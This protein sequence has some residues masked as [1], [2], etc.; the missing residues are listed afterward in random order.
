[1]GV[2]GGPSIRHNLR[3][4]RNRITHRMADGVRVPGTWR[5]VFIHNFTYHLTDLFIYA[6]G[7]IDCWELV[8]LEQF[9]K[10]LRSGWI[11]TT[12]PEGGRASGFHL[13]SW[14]FG[15]PSSH[16]EP[17]TLL[18]EIRDTIDELNDRPNSTAR[19][20][21]A[22]ATFLAHRT[23]ENRAAA[24]AAYLAIPET[25]RVYAL[26]DMD[27]K[28]RPLQVLIAGPDG[29]TQSNP[30]QRVTKAEYLRAIEYFEKQPP[31]TTE[32]TAP[33]PADGPVTAHAPAIKL[34]RGHPQ[35]PAA[36]PDVRV[37]RNEHPAPIIFGGVTYPSVAHAYWALAVAD[38]EV[39]DTIIKGDTGRLP[40]ALAAEA[41]RREGWENART[42]V[43]TGLL[44]A[45]FDQHP[46][47]AEILLTTDDGT[48]LYD[49]Q[50]AFW[51]DNGGGGRNWTGRL[52]ELVRSELQARRAGIEGL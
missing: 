2:P 25:H 42:A 29:T 6:D 31:R 4:L 33:D 35:K 36:G 27:A 30:E 44:R 40:H 9:E 5:H 46:D 15:E 32:R 37:L 8:T 49:D 17:D 14:K 20:M 28:D 47:L 7:L 48:V 51:G 23:A 1:M 50:S 39:R 19:C 52:L 18:A 10:K 21:E 41:P 24:L 38:P 43:M 13:A 26:G 45:K 22:V 12:L 11:A 34:Y 16:I 3:M